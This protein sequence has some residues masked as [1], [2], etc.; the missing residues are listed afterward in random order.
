VIS[1]EP[2]RPTDDEVAAIL[3]ALNALKP[4]DA[5]TPAAPAS[6]WKRAARAESVDVF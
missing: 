2:V 4:T 5:V 1:F 3:A 6:Q